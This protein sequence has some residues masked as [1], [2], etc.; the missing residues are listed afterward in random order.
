MNAAAAALKTALIHALWQD[1]VIGLLLGVALVMLR[2]RSPNARYLAACLA[3]AAMFV[4]P[5]LTMMAQY[6]S[7]RPTGATTLVSAGPAPDLTAYSQGSSRIWTDASPAAQGAVLDVVEAWT[8]PLWLVGVLVFSLR[9]I[10]AATHVTTLCRRGAPAD[11]SVARTVQRLTASMGIGQPVKVFI[12]TL[13]TG[14]ATVGWLRPIIILPPAS[15][16]GLT[17]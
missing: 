17:T 10:S 9:F 7:V 13:T 16:M 8:L 4:V 1:A 15:A 2:R 12:S 14:P 6:G 5:V 3:L 11:A